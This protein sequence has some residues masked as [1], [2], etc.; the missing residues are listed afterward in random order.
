MSQGTI[1]ENIISSMSELVQKA[2]KQVHL[3]YIKRTCSHTP[4]LQK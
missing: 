2:L 1:V 4:I 3:I